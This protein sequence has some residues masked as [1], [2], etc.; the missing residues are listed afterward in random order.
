MREDVILYEQK[1]GCMGLLYMVNISLGESLQVRVSTEAS[2]GDIVVWAC[3]RP[4]NLS[5]KVCDIF[6]TLL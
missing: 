1:V 3:Y 5:E 4:P 2:K 6:K